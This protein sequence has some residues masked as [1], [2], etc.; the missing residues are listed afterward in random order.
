MGQRPDREDLWV[1]DGD[2]IG[3]PCG[4]IREAGATDQLVSARVGSVLVEVQVNRLWPA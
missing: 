1:V 4:G 2:Q 3:H